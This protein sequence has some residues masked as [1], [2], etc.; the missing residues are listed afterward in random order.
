MKN[1][2]HHGPTDDLNARQNACVTFVDDEDV[3]GKVILDIGCGFG[4]CEQNFLERGAKEVTG[5]ELSDAD[6]VAARQGLRDPRARFL[7]GS[8][9][10]LPFADDSFDTV[11]SWEVIEHIPPS[12]EDLMFAEIF[13]VLR[14]GGSFYL[15]TPNDHILAKLLDPAWWLIGHRHYSTANLTGYARKHHF[16][17]VDAHIRGGIWT[18]MGTV[19]MYIAKWIFRRRPFFVE[20]FDAQDKREYSTRTGL[21]NAFLKA[22]KGSALSSPITYLSDDEEKKMTRETV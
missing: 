20:F 11:V 15:S 14:P 6:L 3:A 1:I 10:K 16:E 18:V 21:A 8:A 13:R 17:S 2:L 12:T 7:T 9:L 4:W 5:I 19:N 22:K